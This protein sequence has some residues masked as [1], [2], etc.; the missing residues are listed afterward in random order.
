MKII[1]YTVYLYSMKDI[2]KKNRHSGQ[3]MAIKSIDMIEFKGAFNYYGW[4]DRMITS[5]Y[6][7]LT[8]S[9]T[10]ISFAIMLG[11]SI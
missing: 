6:I 8:V 3:P 7:V 9:L 5:S 10:V 11:I 2:Y 1:K 4:I